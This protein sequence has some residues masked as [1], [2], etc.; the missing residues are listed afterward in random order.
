MTKAKLKSVL[1]GLTVRDAMR[2][3][4]IHMFADATIA[5]AIRE[6]IKFKVNAVLVAGERSEALGVVSKTNILGAY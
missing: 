3:L 2:R 4:V 6:M 5:Q 1:S